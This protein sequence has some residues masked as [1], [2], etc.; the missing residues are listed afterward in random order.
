MRVTVAT[1]VVI[2]LK[3]REARQGLLI[4]ETDPQVVLSHGF[5]G[6]IVGTP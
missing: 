4:E 1:T 5:K 6:N 3:I 2:Y